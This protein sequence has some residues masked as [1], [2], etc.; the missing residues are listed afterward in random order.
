MNTPAL[1]SQSLSIVISLVPY[2]R[3]TFRRHLSQKQAVMLVEFDKLKRVRVSSA[4]ADASGMQLIPALQDYQE[5][6]NEIHQKLIAIMGDR[7]SAHIKSLHVSLLP[8][9]AAR[10]LTA[11]S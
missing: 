3:E 1:A 4:A 7:L 6:Q 10:V 2:I 5:H 9:R 8:P 11:C